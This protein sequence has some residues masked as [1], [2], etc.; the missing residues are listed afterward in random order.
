LSDKLTTCV[1]AVNI[2]EAENEYHIELAVPGLKKENF[3]INF[4]KNIL[5]IRLKRKQGMLK[6]VKNTAKRNT[7]IIHS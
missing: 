6:K 1:P 7:A 2:A 5:S 3:K 4:K